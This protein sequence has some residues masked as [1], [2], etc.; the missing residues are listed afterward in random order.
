MGHNLRETIES[1]VRE[2]A[3]AAPEPTPE[4][5]QSMRTA[6]LA[7]L[8]D[9]ENQQAADLLTL[10]AN[11]EATARR[12]KSAQTA[13]ERADAEYQAAC[14]ARFVRAWELSTQIEKEQ[15]LVKAMADPAVMCRIS[16]LRDE[17]DKLQQKVPLETRSQGATNVFR[18]TR[19][20]ILFSTASAAQERCMGLRAILEKLEV[21]KLVG[22]PLAE[23]EAAHAAYS[24]LPSADEY[25]KSETLRQ[26]LDLPGPTP[27]DRRRQ[28]LANLLG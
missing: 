17:L 22:D 24:N 27:M 5:R 11:I 2:M 25:R 21:A 18:A 28:R 12:R 3:Q 6:A 26:S 19:E 20:T 10:D 9:L 23:L 16:E 7:R 8:A 4:E 14:Q 1:V 15:N 13:F